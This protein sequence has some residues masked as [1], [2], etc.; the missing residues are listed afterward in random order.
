MNSQTVQDN[1][2]KYRYG[3]LIGNLTEER[4]GHEGWE[5]NI[6]T[7]QKINLLYIYFFLGII[8]R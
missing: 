7:I 3:V 5:G 6:I 1:V 2:N 8:L 4:F